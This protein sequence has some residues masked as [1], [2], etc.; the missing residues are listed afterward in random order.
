MAAAT[1]AAATTGNDVGTHVVDDEVA[2]TAISSRLTSRV[3]ADHAANRKD[4]IDATADDDGVF[5]SND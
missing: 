4:A 5:R 3:R 1:T 2:M